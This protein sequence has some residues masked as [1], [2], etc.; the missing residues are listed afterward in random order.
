GGRRR[1][2]MERLLL[3]ARLDLSAHQYE[4]GCIGIGSEES[5]FWK[6]A[7]TALVPL[8]V[9]DLIL[10][11]KTF[12]KTTSASP[13]LFRQDINQDGIAEW[14]L[15]DGDYLAALAPDSGRCLYLFDLVTGDE[16]AGNEA[17][18]LGL[19]GKVY[20][21]NVVPPE[22]V[23][24]KVWSGFR[25]SLVSADQLASLRREVPFDEVWFR[26]RIAAESVPHNGQL[27]TQYR[28]EDKKF[29]SLE[30][31]DPDAF[32]E[33]VRRARC[34][35]LNEQIF[36]GGELVFATP[37]L[38]NPAAQCRLVSCAP[39]ASGVV[40]I[41]ETEE[42]QLRKTVRLAGGSL[43]AELAITTNRKSSAPLEIVLRNE[44]CPGY[45]TILLHGRRGLKNNNGAV[46]NDLAGVGAQVGISP[47]PQSEISIPC[48]LAELL[49]HRLTLETS[50][51][52]AATFEIAIEGLRLEPKREAQGLARAEL[53]RD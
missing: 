44:L 51:A 53:P 36:C 17:A 19:G 31:A 30:V 18:S 13:M 35:L 8:R 42:F 52:S 16:L 37:G 21:D 5:A 9:A 24:S 4:F 45:T 23:Q 10:E 39:T 6:R 25:S 43:K 40:W 38:G 1:D 15:T 29:S 46:F 32:F 22:S 50:P 7:A 48:F 49:E 28:V 3:Q 20:D 27:M 14:I 26:Y 41:F 11:Q 33:N 47:T 2:A 12:Q 34:R